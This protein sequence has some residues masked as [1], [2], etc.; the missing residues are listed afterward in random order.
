M[1]I[2]IGKWE[3]CLWVGKKGILEK[4]FYKDLNAYELKKLWSK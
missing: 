2:V 3:V 1:R 4:E